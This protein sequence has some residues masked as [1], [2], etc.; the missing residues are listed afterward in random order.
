[1]KAHTFKNPFNTLALCSVLSS[2]ALSG[3]S[4]C[5]LEH[6]IERGDRCPPRTGGDMPEDRI[7]F[8]VRENNKVCDASNAGGF[9]GSVA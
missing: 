7:S 4:G 6:A 5:T 3:I 9:P 2:I 8:I 1:M